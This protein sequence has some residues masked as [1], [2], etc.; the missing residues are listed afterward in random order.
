MISSRGEEKLFE[1]K[2]ILRVI[3]METMSMAIFFISLSL[4]VPQ[5]MQ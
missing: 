1:Q 5:A 2:I 3:V 4:M